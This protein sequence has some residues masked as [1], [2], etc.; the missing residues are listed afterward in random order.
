MPSD[1]RLVYCRFLEER[2]AEIALRERRHRIPGYSR[3]AG[4]VAVVCLALAGHLSIVWITVPIAVLALL[5]PTCDR[6][7][8]ILERRLRAQRFF[9]RALARLD[10]KWAGTGEPGYGYLDLFG[11]GSPFELLSTARTHIGED[12]LA[13]WPLVPAGPATVRARQEAVSELRPRVDSTFVSR[14]RVP[15]KRQSA[16]RWHDLYWYKHP[17]NRG[18]LVP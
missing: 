1:P 6:L 7:L 13:R 15:N 14:A 4:A 8:R 2:R 9:E 10:G 17:S 3:L 11:A 5:V 16:G 12:T 18:L